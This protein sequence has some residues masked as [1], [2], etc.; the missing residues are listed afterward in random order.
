MN[1]S[2]RR[3]ISWSLTLLFVVTSLTIQLNQFINGDA[4]WLLEVASRLL[5]GKH[6][7]TSIFEVNPPLA[8][9]IY[10][11]SVLI[12][13]AFHLP[14]RY[15]FISYLFILFIACFFVARH[16][17]IKLSSLVELPY[18]TLLTGIAFI[19][20][21]L[22]TYSFSEREQMLLVFTVP[23][24][25]VCMIQLYSNASHFKKNLTPTLLILVGL[26]AGI[27]FC[28]KPYFFTAFILIELCLCWQ[29]RSLWYWLRIKTT[30][31]VLFGALYVVLT[32]LL[33][34]NYLFKVIP[35][36]QRL[37]IPYYNLSWTQLVNSS[38]T[39]YVI[40]ITALVVFGHKNKALR[41]IY[42]VLCLAM[43][44]FYFTYLLQFKPWYY[45]KLPC[46]AV[47]VLL[48]LLLSHDAINQIQQGEATIWI[49]VIQ[50]IIAIYLFSYPIS[51]AYYRTRFSTTKYHA[52]NS[53]ANQFIRFI[54]Q[55]HYQGFLLDL[56]PSMSPA[57]YI[58][59][60]TSL[61]YGSRYGNATILL[62]GLLHIER[63]GEK[64]PAFYQEARQYFFSSINQDIRTYRPC[65]LFVDESR[66]KKY[67]GTMRVNLLA[68]L[69]QYQPLAKLLTGYHK[70]AAYGHFALYA[71]DSASAYL[72]PKKA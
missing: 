8:P 54:K 24:F 41:F 50:F 18:Y 13:K 67:F 11:P 45:H 51:N 14:L 63:S 57:T 69:K 19:E 35:L 25:L 53:V 3:L 64:P 44:G 60:S 39:Y 70:V 61:N 28:L 59:D 2:H 30:L 10:A 52:T 5:A 65:Y 9:L 12:A 31:P 72:S 21:T 49:S 20:L 37:Y 58:V 32:W 1:T 38:L 62:V 56:S 4:S 66:H 17:L 43:I 47:G 22:F 6:Y 36:A 23:Y 26:M 33:F 15:T 55:H 68:Y 29:K 42:V 48:L 46:V 40:M 7:Y 71:P 27:G 16:C 34:P